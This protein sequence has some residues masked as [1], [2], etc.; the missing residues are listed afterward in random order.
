MAWGRSADGETGL[1]GRNGASV[2]GCV[3]S[4][5]VGGKTAKRRGVPGNIEFVALLEP[6]GEGLEAR[7]DESVAG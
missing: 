4:P 3:Q 1:T 5:L 2:L 6:L 7:A